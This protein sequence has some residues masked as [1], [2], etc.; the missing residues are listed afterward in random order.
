[1]DYIITLCLM[2]DRKAEEAYNELARFTED[3]ELAAFWRS[4]SNEES[5]HV[6][7]WKRLL[8]FS[9]KNE[10][11]KVFADPEKIRHDMENILL[12]MDSL[13]IRTRHHPNV[14]NSF[15]LAFRME[16]HMLHPAFRH[17]FRVLKTIRNEET[18]LDIYEK[19]I[20]RLVEAVEKYGYSTPQLELIGQSISR[21][22]KENVDLME[23]SDID[24]LTGLYNRR[25][26]IHSFPDRHKG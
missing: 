10:M 21:F 8:E 1:M 24:E 2:V 6:A 14:V 15:L 9:R 4:M 19:H 20:T 16:F 23:K 26:G 11:P 18:P 13:L 17:L 5:G 25:G 12:Q 22:W 3:P 7:Y